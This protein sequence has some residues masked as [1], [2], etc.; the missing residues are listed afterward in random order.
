MSFSDFI[1]PKVQSAQS[2]LQD[3]EDLEEVGES[4]VRRFKFLK[5]R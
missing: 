3:Y 5:R 1:L 2:F 4:R